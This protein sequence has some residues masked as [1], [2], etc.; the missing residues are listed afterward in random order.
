MKEMK[1]CLKRDEEREGKRR[2]F[3]EAFKSCVKGILTQNITQE[4][5]IMLWK[6]NTYTNTEMNWD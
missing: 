5:G 3:L 6:T 1:V 4:R 2:N